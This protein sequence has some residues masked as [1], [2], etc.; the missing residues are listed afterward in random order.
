MSA[1]AELLPWQEPLTTDALLLILEA[2]A[3]AAAA[4]AEHI[5]T[6]PQGTAARSRAAA[7]LPALLD[8]SHHCREAEAAVQRLAILA[9]GAAQQQGQQAA[10]GAL[11]PCAA[12]YLRLMSVFDAAGAPHEAARLAVEV[13]GGNLPLAQPEGEHEGGT[14]PSST[15]AAVEGLVEGA[16]ATANGAGLMRLAMELFLELLRRR[17]GTSHRGVMAQVQAWV[18]TYVPQLTVKPE[19]SSRRSRRYA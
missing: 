8:P 14:S 4:A 12:V 9:A 19:L 16:M 15:A 5:R 1:V 3:A 10:A 18:S 17:G 2:R 7:D 6:H 13:L 11:P